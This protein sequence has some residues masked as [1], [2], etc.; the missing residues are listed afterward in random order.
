MFHKKTAVPA[1]RG[2]VAAALAVLALGWTQPAR[3]AFPDHPI[4]AIIPFSTGGQSD[5]QGRIIASAL[6]QV[7]GQPVVVE[8]KPGAGGNLGIGL[9]QRAKPDG[10]TIVL[11][12]IALT[13]NPALY[14][15]LGW[16]VDK[17][18]PVAVFG[19]VP[20]TLV[21]NTKKFPTGNLRDFVARARAEPG[22]WNFSSANNGI[23]EELFALAAG[24]KITTI[25]YGGAGEAITAVASGEADAA[26]TSV[27]G[28]LPFAAAGTV[29]VLTVSGD[30]R[31]ASLPD[32]PSAVEAG[33]PGYKLQSYIMMVAPKGVP[34]DV[35]KVLNDAANK[36]VTDPEVIDRFRKVATDL[37]KS[38]IAESEAFF[39]A[40]MAAYKKVIEEGHIPMIE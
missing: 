17:I 28:V 10:Y 7:L 18:Q 39:K 40:D 6:G 27:L 15:N 32:V 11:S 23:N 33:V 8:N 12:S 9:G 35:L 1:I 25:P 5:V 26:T 21:V 34:A 19:E 31:S 38:T 22:K 29:R 36:V 13:I 2:S 4:T 30:K 37:H 16:E 20:V 14:K 24:I 3:A